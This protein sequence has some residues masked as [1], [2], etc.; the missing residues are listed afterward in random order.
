[1]AG[2]ACILNKSKAEDIAKT[3][4]IG[5]RIAKRL[6]DYRNEH[7]AFKSMDELEN[8]PGFGKNVIEKLRSECDLDER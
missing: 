7:G 2:K 1:M 3:A 5:N 6:V 4:G 8:V